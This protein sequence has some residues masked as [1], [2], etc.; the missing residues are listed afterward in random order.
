MTTAAEQ[1][2]LTEHP[3]RAWEKKFPPVL[4][5]GFFL[6][7]LLQMSQHVMWRD[8][9]RTWQVCRECS[10]PVALWQAMRWEGVPVLW[11]WIVWVLT[12]I[13]SNPFLM[14]FTH[15]LISTA[16]VY[17][18]ARWSPFSLA[19]RALFA[20][21]YFPLFEYGMLTRN[22]SL[23]FLH[24]LIAC[25]LIS[26]PRVRFCPLTIVLLLLTQVSIW[27]AG[28]AGLMLLIAT[29]KAY[30]SG[31]QNWPSAGGILLA[32]V[33]V[34]MGALVCYVEVLPGPGPTFTATWLRIGPLERLLRTIGAIYR[35]WLPIPSWSVHFWNTN[36]LD[37][38]PRPGGG[39]PSLIN[40]AGIV[41]DF[42]WVL[43]AALGAGL[44]LGAIVVLLRR[45]IALALLLLGCGGLLGFEYYFHGTNRH[46]GHLF[47]I[48]ICACWLASTTP[49]WSRASQWVGQIL[50][51]LDRA[52][53]PVLLAIL[54]INAMIGTGA[55]VAGMSLQFSATKQAGNYIKQNFGDRVVLV[56]MQDYCVSPI[57]QWLDREIYFPQMAKSARYNTQN[58][59]ARYSVGEG[60]P[61]LPKMVELGE[62]HNADVLLI[63]SHVPGFNP[64]PPD[65]ISVPGRPARVLRTR[66]LPKFLN[67][68]V[69]D[70]GIELYLF[71]VVRPA[72][73]S[74]FD[75]RP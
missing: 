51:W 13:S 56:G 58:G 36:I 25:V 73:R 28:L 32:G 40:L 9:I 33:V 34:L 65:P 29:A 22:Y 6:A 17:I 48:L 5:T 10:G 61:L 64:D 1:P 18:V 55:A 12:R 21:G 74:P 42:M 19:S 26:Q 70:E 37:P 11:Y 7:V 66:I 38:K 4:A 53:G 52:R 14:Q 57:A 15:A 43:Q 2:T 75:L 47:M 67:S 39:S 62:R 60:N 30:T 63:W 44:F 16:V 45:P 41:I 50:T 27:G 23:V 54:T 20:L 31:R 46:H 35:G 24:L 49:A 71:S 59:D 3:Q 8:E 72:E 68:V 69:E